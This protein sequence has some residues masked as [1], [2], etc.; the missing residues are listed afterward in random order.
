M[1]SPNSA[2]AQ[3]SPAPVHVTNSFHFI[4]PA[5]LSQAAPLFGPEGERCWTGPHWNPEFLHPQRVKD[6]PFHDQQGAVFTI[7]N[8]PHKSVWVNTLFDLA[9]GRMQYVAF[10]PGALVSTVEV[11]LTPL[12]AS[13]TGV[14]VTYARTALDPAANVDVEAIGAADRENGP[15]WQQSIEA[16]LRQRSAGN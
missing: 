7:Q 5:P 15:K 10:T 2:A 13:T 14:E 8:G 3:T 11:R 6:H 16:S 9:N 12:T 4:V 1:R